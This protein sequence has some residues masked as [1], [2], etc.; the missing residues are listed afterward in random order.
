MSITDAVSDALEA[1]LLG[2]SAIETGINTLDTVLSL[3]YRLHYHTLGNGLA[4]DVAR[5]LKSECRRL[6]VALDGSIAIAGDPEAYSIVEKTL[7]NC[8]A[9]IAYHQ[10]DSESLP[11]L[12]QATK[13]KIGKSKSYAEFWK[14]LDLENLYYQGLINKDPKDLYISQLL[15]YINEIPLISHGLLHSYLTLIARKLKTISL[16]QLCNDMKSQAPFVCYLYLLSTSKPSKDDD[17][18]F[19]SL[20]TKIVNNAKFPL[21]SQ[22]NDSNLEQLHVCLHHY[23]EIEGLEFATEWNDL[24]ISSLKRTFQSKIVARS[25][26]SLNGFNNTDDT[27]RECILSFNNYLKYSDKELELTSDTHDIY[28]DPIAIIDALTIIL[29]RTTERDNI[30]NIFDFEHVTELLQ[31]NLKKLYSKY[32]LG[33]VEPAIAQKYLSNSTRLVL[34]VTISC[35]LIKAWRTLYNIRSASLDYLIANELPSYLC[36]SISLAM[37]NNNGN[38]NPYLRDLQFQ[39]AYCLAQQRQ[40]EACI[41]YLE[42]AILEAVPTFYKAWHLLALCRSIQEDKEISYKIICSVMNAMDQEFA[43]IQ[44]KNISQENKWQYIH[45]K[46]TE[47]HLIN[48][49]FGT[50]EALESLPELF[51]SYHKLFG[52]SPKDEI[53]GPLSRSPEYLLQSIWLLAAQLYMNNAEHFEDAKGAIKEAK[54]VSNDFTNV[55]ISITNGHLLFKLGK[56]TESISH[57]EDALHCDD[58]NVDAIIG[59]AAFVFP[60]DTTTSASEQ[61][62]IDYCK[63]Q[64]SEEVN[65]KNK[66]AGDDY[67]LF[68][69]NDVNKSAAFARLKLLIDCSLNKS[70]DAYYSPEIWWYLSLIHEKYGNNE[71]SDTLLNCIQNKETCPLRSFKFCNY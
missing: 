71:I 33:L 37:T 41:E 13:L 66:F 56:F 50:D 5:V 49:I 48:E 46:I 3:Q 68:C 26:M 65:E 4:N 36:N 9:V 15:R 6:Q 1:R 17:T 2:A 20:A 70:I 29:Q 51:T 18:F 44:F 63:L 47:I 53:K 30:T 7:L 23:F 52:D 57:F 54:A 60:N 16:N 14:L 32:H 22:S 69:G 61:Q 43:S 55:N 42:N 34:P 19:L 58:L 27:I 28:N 59:F 39:Y 31:I 11:L 24:I 35:I 40:I 64:N 38:E 62:L 21:A 25:T 12:K 45:I 67:E 10:G 8:L